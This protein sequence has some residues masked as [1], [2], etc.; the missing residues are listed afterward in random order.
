MNTDFLDFWTATK[1]T[2]NYYIE[3]KVDK[4]PKDRTPLGWVLPCEV[5][6]TNKTTV[7]QDYAITVGFDNGQEYL[8]WFEVEAMYH[9]ANHTRLYRTQTYLDPQQINEFT[10]MSILS[11]SRFN[12]GVN[13]NNVGAPLLS[14]GWVGRLIDI[15]P[16]SLYHDK[17]KE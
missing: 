12:G 4:Q 17:D 14:S 1:T 15:L 9:A 8:G 13:R 6:I 3:V 11:V 7:R 2:D 10:R 5:T 16:N